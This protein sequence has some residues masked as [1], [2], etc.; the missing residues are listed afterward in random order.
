ML[1]SCVFRKWLATFSVAWCCGLSA[2]LWSFGALAD[3]PSNAPPPFACEIRYHF[4]EHFRHAKPGEKSVSAPTFEREGLPISRVEISQGI[5]KRVLDGRVAH[6][7]YLFLVKV[8][9]EIENE[10]GILEVN[11]LDSSRR[12]LIGFPKSMP[13]PLT[14]AGESSRKAFEL[15]ISKT[16][17]REIRETLLLPEQF[18]T[19]VD[20]IIGM[21]EDFLS[22]DF[23]K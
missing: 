21:D 9:P 15:P 14:T 11:V 6:L 12:P 19:H 17:K 18:L 4:R 7:P 22:Q 23:P 13:N 20:L 2:G 5:A 3:E 1:N 16:L 10:A 8:R